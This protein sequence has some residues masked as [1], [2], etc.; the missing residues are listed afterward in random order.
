MTEQ[1]EEAMRLSAALAQA[2]NSAALSGEIA[3]KKEALAAREE[4]IARLHQR[5]A[6][7]DVRAQAAMGRE[8]ALQ[9]QL[10]AL[11]SS[12]SWRITAPLRFAKHLLTRFLTFNNRLSN[13]LV[14]SPRTELPVTDQLDL[15]AE[16]NN[17]RR[18]YLRLVRTRERIWASR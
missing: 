10:A 7:M 11:H 16:P 2:A 4:E 1:A 15:N 6:E 12:T 9:Q 17:V 18:L 13:A 14:S 8:I 5:I 3:L